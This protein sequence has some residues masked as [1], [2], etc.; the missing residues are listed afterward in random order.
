MGENLTNTGFKLLKKYIENNCG[1]D[2]PDEKAYLIETRLSSIL[3]KQGLN[4]FEELY[5]HIINN[6]CTSISEELIDAITTHETLWFRDKFPWTVLEKIYLPAYIKSIRNGEKKKIRIW[7]AATSTGQEAYSTAMCIDSWLLRNGITDVSLD[8]FEI[9]ATDISG[10]VLNYAKA[11]V[12]DDISV[13][14]G[15]DISF[16]NKY[17]KNEGAVWK[18]NDTIKASVKFD[19]FNLQSSFILLGKFDVVFC[20][21][22]L[23][24]FSNILREEILKKLSSCMEPDSVFFIGSSELYAVINMQ[25]DTVQSENGVYY[26]R[27]KT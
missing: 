1:L 5:Y 17:F 3:A 6:N 12:Y 7:S 27:K 13:T 10:S 4:S 18:I 14:R 9:L 25:F 26:T 16:R 23:I 8:N 22:V 20:R 2:I 21:Y 15:L 11:G 19:K 24:Y